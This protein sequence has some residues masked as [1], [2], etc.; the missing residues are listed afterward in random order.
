MTNKVYGESDEKISEDDSTSESKSD[1]ELDQ[2]EESD[3]LRSPESDGTSK[4]VH[5]ALKKLHTSYNPT[6]SA[7][8]VGDDLALVGSTDD[9][10]EN[11]MTFA[12]AWNHE[13]KKERMPWQAAIKKEFEGIIDQ[14]VWRC[15][16]KSKGGKRNKSPKGN[17]WSAI[18]VALH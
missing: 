10:H 7:L 3:Y 5:N 12:Q 16:R 6:L 8:L 18:P 15:G 17:T 4:R 14:R 11:P 9:L 1:E 13:N 2:K